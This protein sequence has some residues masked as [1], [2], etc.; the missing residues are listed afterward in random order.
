M[1]ERIANYIKRGLDYPIEEDMRF[2][3]K[4]GIHY[5]LD[6]RE[7]SKLYLSANLKFDA[8]GVP[9]FNYAIV[10]SPNNK[11]GLI[12][13]ITYICWYALS[14]LH[15]YLE[16]DDPRAKDDFLKQAD[17]LLDNNTV[18]GSMVCWQITFPWNVYGIWLPVPRVSS[19]DQGLAV[20]VLVRAYLLTSDERYLEI[21]KKAEPFYDVSLDEGGFKATLRD[22]SIFYEMYP[23]GKLSMILDGHIFSLMGLYDLYSVTKDKKT[24]Q[25]FDSAVATVVDNIAYWNWWDM[26]SWF[27][28]LYL[29]SVM[30]HKINLCWLRVLSEISDK[31]ELRILADK[32]ER[33]YTDKI[34][35]LYLKLRMFFSSRLFF[36]T[37]AFLG[38]RAGRRPL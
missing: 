12:Y 8:Q 14:R 11:A 36:M 20:S 6:F 16:D 27:G 17:W 18:S 29:S 34:L 19:M 28:C 32:W 1:F 10:P 15:D 31:D 21:A 5:H 38:R 22:G 13:S 35:R 25:R 33:G 3:Y 4:K 23:S 7:L 30:Y 37:N 24:R 26:W 9:R 2:L